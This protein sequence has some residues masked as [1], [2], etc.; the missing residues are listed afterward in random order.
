MA[1]S[2][3][4]LIPDDLVYETPRKTA[5]GILDWKE[6]SWILHPHNTGVASN[7]PKFLPKML[8]DDRL[9]EHKCI[10][11]GSVLQGVDSICLRE[12]EAKSE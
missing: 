8:D 2:P 6:I 4:C 10:F 7:L 1:S 12:D 3:G 11:R 9:Y 5:E